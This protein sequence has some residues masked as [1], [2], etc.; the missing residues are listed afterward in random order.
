MD[1]EKKEYADVAMTWNPVELYVDLV[2]CPI[3]H[4]VFNRN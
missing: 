3:S 2:T 4:F 1:G